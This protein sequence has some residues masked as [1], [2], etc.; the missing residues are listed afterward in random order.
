MPHPVVNDTQYQIV[1]TL[2]IKYTITPARS[3]NS[4]GNTGAASFMFMG[5]RD[6]REFIC[7]LMKQKFVFMKFKN[8]RP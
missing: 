1:L 2:E 3:R 8:W 7:F 6:G 5:I 4:W